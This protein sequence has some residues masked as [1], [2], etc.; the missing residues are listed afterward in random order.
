MPSQDI[1]QSSLLLLSEIRYDD[2]SEFGISEQFSQFW[3]FVLPLCVAFLLV[4]FNL[5][6]SDKIYALS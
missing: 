2:F 3:I 5:V 6:S 1:S 4:L